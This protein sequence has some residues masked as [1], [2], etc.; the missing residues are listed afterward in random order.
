MGFSSGFMRCEA[1]GVTRWVSSNG[2]NTIFK[3]YTITCVFAMIIFLI[4]M[5]KI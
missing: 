1:E 4:R 5:T 2:M 3:A